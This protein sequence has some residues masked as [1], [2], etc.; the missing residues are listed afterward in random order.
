MFGNGYSIGGHYPR[1]DELFSGTLK[2]YRFY[3]RVLTDAEVAHNRQV[4]SARFF[5][6][7]ATTNVFVVAGGGTQTEAG[8]Y[9]VEGSWTF[10]AETTVDKHGEIVPGMRYSVETLVNGAWENRQ[11]YNGNSYTYTEGVSPVTVRLE[12]L[13]HPAGGMILVR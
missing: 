6:E 13:G 1:K 3:N 5:G 7:L 9:K 12:W 10:T 11:I 4:D 2:S 8:A